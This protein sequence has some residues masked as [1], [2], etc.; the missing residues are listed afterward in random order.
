MRTNKN[1]ASVIIILL[2]S[3]SLLSCSQKDTAP[4]TEVV[5][6]E[7]MELPEP[8]IKSKLSLEETIYNRRSVRE[9]SAEK[10]SLEDISQVLWAAQGITDSSTGFRSSPSAGALYPLELFFITEE[11]LYHYI[12]EGHKAEKLASE[13]KRAALAKACVSQDFIEQAPLSIVI[14]AVF[15]RTE[16]KYGERGKRY[17]YLEAGHAC[18]NIL[19]QATS[20]GLGA[21][22]VGAFYDEELIKVLGI[23]KDHFPIYVIPLGHTEY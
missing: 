11:G 2:L 22:P 8:S 7:T 21:V 4:A 3:I 18:Q 17:V 12:P 23:T 1:I 9:F 20:L 19:L 15:E 13:D 10:L 5:K 6:T 16:Q 14:T